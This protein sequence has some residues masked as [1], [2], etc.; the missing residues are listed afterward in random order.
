MASGKQKRDTII[1]AALRDALELTDSDTGLSNNQLYSCLL[2]HLERHPDGQDLLRDLGKMEAV[3]IAKRQMRSMRSPLDTRLAFSVEREVDI[4]E[5]G[6]PVF[7]QRWIHYSRVLASTDLADRV[8]DGYRNRAQA[9]MVEANKTWR[10]AKHMNPQYQ[11]PLPFPNVAVD[12][13]EEGATA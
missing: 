3:T 2:D 13:G 4:D 9:N 12:D 11:R 1:H 8:I 6:H 10:G 7:D 5:S